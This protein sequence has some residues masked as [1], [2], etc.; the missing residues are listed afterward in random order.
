MLSSQRFEHLLHHLKRIIKIPLL[1]SK[2]NPFLLSTL[3]SKCRS[4]TSE[5]HSF[6]VSYLINNCGFLPETALKASKCVR[7]KT[8]QKPDSVIAFFRNHAFSDSVINSIIRKAPNVLNCDPNERILPKFEFLRS[9][10]ASSSDIVELVD[11]NPRILYSSLENNI[12]PTFE[13]VRRFL[14]SDKETIDS[15]LTCGCFF[16]DGRVARNLRFLLDYGVTDS[17][18]SFLMRKRLLIILCDMKGA[19]DEVKKMGF[20]P[21]KLKFAIALQAKMTIPKSRWDA[22]VDALKSWGWTE[23]MILDAFRKRPHYMLTSK[24]KINE[25]MRFWVNQLGWNPLILVNRTEIFGYSL[26]KRVIPR[27]FV[28]QY[29]LS[30]G[31]IKKDTSLSTPFAI[32]EKLFLEKYVNCFKEESCQLLKLYQKKMSDSVQEEKEDGAASG[33]YQMVNL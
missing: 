31:L 30:N 2:G 18:I 21:S 4:T 11:R 6:T 22:K 33:G 28:F 27:A 26:E 5:T 10:G 3:S 23:K 24:D 13:L 9:K 32:T 17:N 25:M 8:A 7:F 29:L 19:V 16:A 14:Q 20:V 1:T 15:I 12:I